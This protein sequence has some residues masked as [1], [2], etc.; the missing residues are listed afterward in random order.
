MTF[1]SHFNSLFWF[2]NGPESLLPA[3]NP[4][5]FDQKKTKLLPELEGSRMTYFWRSWFDKAN[6][7]E[8]FCIS[9]DV[10]VP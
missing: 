1:S 7:A 2:C 5:S 6:Q 8:I 4:L 10:L 3:M 9:Q